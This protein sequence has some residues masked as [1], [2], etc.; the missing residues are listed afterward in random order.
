MTDLSLI[1]GG[2]GG[3]NN[4]R[5]LI[6][7]PTVFYFIVIFTLLSEFVEALRF[8]CASLTD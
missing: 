3:T 6:L 2:F 7:E 5:I 1:S 4:A 8:R